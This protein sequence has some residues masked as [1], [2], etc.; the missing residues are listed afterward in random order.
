MGY[1]I[2]LNLAWDELELDAPSKCTITLLRDN[3]KVKVGE[4]VVLLESSSAPAEVVESVLILHYLIGFLKHGFHPT[5][6]WISFRETEGGKI[7]WPAFRNSTIEPLIECFQRDS[8]G[9]VKNLIERF[10]R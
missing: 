4:R 2:S 1:E 10:G 8:D 3:Y 6:K 5:G 7:F 9:L